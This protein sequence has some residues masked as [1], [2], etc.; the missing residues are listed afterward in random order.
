MSRGPSS[1]KM[2]A[3]EP[4]AGPAPPPA[5]PPTPVPAPAAAGLSPS[6]LAEPRPLHRIR[7]WELGLVIGLCLALYLP[8]LGNYGLWD[9]W[10][11]H[12]AE[13]ARRM[14]EDQDWIRLRWENENFR[15]KPVLTFWMVG[16]GFKL[17]GVGDEGGFS[18]EMVASSAV[19]WAVRLPFALWGV[20]GLTI[21]WIALARLYSRR[22]AWIAT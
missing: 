21:L 9:P 17:L 15:S 10:E 5:A 16:A 13:V 4:E 14:L 18:G 1:K 19:E 20:F 11:T 3:A 8:L 22:A 2:G 6:T 7:V 12:Y